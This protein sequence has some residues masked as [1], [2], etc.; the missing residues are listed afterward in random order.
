MCICPILLV[1]L[2]FAACSQTIKH[3]YRF[4][5]TKRLQ[6]SHCESLCAKIAADAQAPTYGDRLLCEAALEGGDPG[7][8]LPGKEPR[9]S[10]IYIPRLRTRQ[11]NGADCSLKQ[12]PTAAGG[13]A[14]SK[15]G[16]GRPIGSSGTRIR[17]SSCTCGAQAGTG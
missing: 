3:E 7:A 4:K 17:S 12:L 5:G 14:G 15:P 2:I 13:S 9:V 6:A 8:S 10:K 16:M 11:G 1:L